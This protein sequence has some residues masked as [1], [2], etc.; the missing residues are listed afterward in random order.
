MTLMLSMGLNLTK[1]NSF[2]VNSLLYTK[3]S[4]KHEPV[5]HF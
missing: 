2:K 4:V 5:Q 1:E 3:I